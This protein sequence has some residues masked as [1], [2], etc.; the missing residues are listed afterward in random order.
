MLLGLLHSIN[1]LQEALLLLLLHLGLLAASRL[2]NLAALLLL[3]ECLLVSL[4]LRHRVSLHLCEVRCDVL[5][6]RD[7]ALWLLRWVREAGVG[8]GPRRWLL[9][10]LHR[11]L[12]EFPWLLCDHASVLIEGFEDG[13]RLR[14]RRLRILG[15][16]DG[17]LVLFL[18][19]LANLCRLL[20]VGAERVDHIAGFQNFI[21]QQRHSRLALL[22]LRADACELALLADLRGVAL[23]DLKVAPVLVIVLVLLLCHQ[24]EDHLLDHVVDCS[25][26]GRA[27]DPGCHFLGEVLKGLRVRALSLLAQ[28]SHGPHPV[29]IWRLPQDLEE[30]ERRGWRHR[31]LGHLDADTSDLCE[32]VDP[33][34]HGLHLAGPQ[35]RAFLPLRLLQIAGA[36]RVGKA[37]GVRLEVI[38]CVLQIC[39]RSQERRR[40]LSEGCA[41][42]CLC[43]CRGRNSAV[44][45]VLRKLVRI[46]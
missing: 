19:S 44:T 35:R 15:I 4:L 26:R 9:R 7:D 16:L 1:P 38:L 34:C 18:A 14:N 28:E 2:L 8:C 24:P 17:Q 43:S 12:Q 6:D 46:D 10:Q 21:G 37:L 3:V 45:G 20:N 39:L 22:Q 36:L 41:L 32:D 11:L 30:S 25:K 33:G 13:G 42:R 5:Q 29:V 40:C 23:L 27:R 31:I